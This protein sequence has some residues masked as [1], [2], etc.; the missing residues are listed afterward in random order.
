M[1]RCG[2]V[3]WERIKKFIALQKAALFESEPLFNGSRDLCTAPE[4][5][6]LFPSRGFIS[7][8]E[9][10]RWQWKRSIKVENLPNL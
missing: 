10:L 2:S 1:R 8:A 4:W 5:F 3:V 6:P 9:Y 7:V